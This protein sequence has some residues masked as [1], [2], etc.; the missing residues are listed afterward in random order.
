M[1][2]NFSVWLRETGRLYLRYM[3][4]GVA[5]VPFASAA[6]FAKQAR[7]LRLI[8]SLFEKG[9]CASRKNGGVRF[10]LLRSAAGDSFCGQCYHYHLSTSCVRKAVQSERAFPSRS[11]GTA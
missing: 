1:G 5:S 9:R 7:P 2:A 8:P 11:F 4:V 6:V 3:A 10:T